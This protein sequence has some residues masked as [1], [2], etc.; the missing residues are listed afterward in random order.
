MG[1]FYLKNSKKW[2]SARGNLHICSFICQVASA[3]RLRSDLCGFRVKLWPVSVTITSLN[4]SK[5]EAIPLSV[6]LKNTS[7][8]A[9]LSSHYP[10]FMLNAKQESSEYQF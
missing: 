7:E 4:R 5:K 1:Y 10:F 8:F 2:S 3:R 6:L 9:D